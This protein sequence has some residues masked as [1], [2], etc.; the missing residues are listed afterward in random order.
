ME[1]LPDTCLLDPLCLL[2]FGDCTD[3]ELAELVLQGVVDPDDA[4]ELRRLR[5]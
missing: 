1:H 4:C 2:V 3:D 5:A